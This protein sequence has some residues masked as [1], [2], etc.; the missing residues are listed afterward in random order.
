MAIFY[1]NICV[2]YVFSLCSRWFVKNQP[3]LAPARPNVL[4]A[5]VAL[6]SMVLVAG[7]RKNIGDTYFYMY[8]YAQNNYNLESLVGQKDIGFNVFQMLLQTISSDPQI[9]VFVVALL[10]NVLVFITYYKYS[11]LFELSLYVYITSGMFLMSMNGIR[12]FLAAAI[13][14]AATKYIFNGNWKK[15]MLVVL[16]AA[17]FH[18]SALILIPIYFIVRRKAWSWTTSILLVMS[19]MIVIGFNQFSSALFSVLENSQYSD[20][21][22]FSEGGT[23]I[24]R[25]AVWGVPVIFAFLG[26]NKLRELFPQ[27]DYVVNMALIAFVFMIISTQNWIFAR[28]TFYFGLYS[29]LLMSWIVQLFVS[30][31]RKIIYYLILIC[32]FIYYFYENVFSLGIWYESDYLKF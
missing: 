4:F 12:Q 26:R 9:L 6:I 5:L 27:S 28:F 17:Q 24:L 25:V 29:P 1:M 13:A 2:V 23:N 22:N 7:L 14:F 30:R 21:K 3:A 31:E 19:I 8:S 16:L 10:T 18:Q 32:Y 15:Y 20:Y 11:K